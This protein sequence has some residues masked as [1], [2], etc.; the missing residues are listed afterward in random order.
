MSDE[1]YNVNGLRRHN[2]MAQATDTKPAED[3]GHDRVPDN[4]MNSTQELQNTLLVTMGQV[5]H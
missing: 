3:A 1:E 5:Y 2:F 4:H